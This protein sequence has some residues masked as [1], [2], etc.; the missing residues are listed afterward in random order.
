MFVAGIN[1]S[2]HFFAWRYVSIRHYSEDPEFRAYAMILVVLSLLVVAGLAALAVFV[3]VRAA[4][5]YG[6][7]FLPAY[8]ATVEQSTREQAELFVESMVS[9]LLGG[10]TLMANA[11]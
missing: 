5:G 1:F 2:L 4:G 10:C 9:T 6:N 7:M 8:D 11:E 3:A